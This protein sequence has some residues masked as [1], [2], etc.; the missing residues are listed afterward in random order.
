MGTVCRT[1]RRGPGI[2]GRLLRAGYCVPTAAGRVLRA[3]RCGRVAAGNVSR[4]GRR[5]RAAADA[6][7]RMG[8]R[9]DGLPWT[10]RSRRAAAD[11]VGR[12][13]PGTWAPG[14]GGCGQRVA[15]GVP[16]GQGVAGGVSRAGRRRQAQ[17]RGP[18]ATCRGRRAAAEGLSRANRRRRARPGGVGSVS[19]AAGRWGRVSRAGRRERGA[20]G[21]PPRTGHCRRAAAN[22]VPQASHHGPGIAGRPPR[23][24]CRRRAAR[25]DHRSRR[26][27]TLAFAS[28]A[29]RA[30]GRR[31]VFRWCRGP[32]A[33]SPSPGRHRTWR[34]PART[35]R[36]PRCPSRWCCA[37]SGRRSPAV[38]ASG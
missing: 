30:M 34:A 4:T 16:R 9:A 11:G 35:G 14:H 25:A 1:G 12:G 10:G 37:T 7:P 27:D 24:G 31:P 23:T 20:T 33:G 5:R 38:R 26:D 19:R 15:V 36:R 18:W 21:R 17:P 8:H 22:G 28:A 13:G 6:L 29:R 3:D 32:G 2:A